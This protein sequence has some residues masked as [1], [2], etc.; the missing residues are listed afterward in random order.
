ME[1][2]G[3]FGTTGSGSDCGSELLDDVVLVV[4]CELLSTLEVLDETGGSLSVLLEETVVED[5]LYSGTGCGS[6]DGSAG[7]TSGSELLDCGTTT[8]TCGFE[9]VLDDELGEVSE[10]LLLDAEKLPACDELAVEEDSP[11]DISPIPTTVTVEC[12]AFSVQPP[13][14]HTANASDRTVM[15]LFFIILSPNI[16]YLYFCL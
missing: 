11:V 16:F 4:L 6:Y 3:G 9:E 7:S 14:M 8:L 13:S 12:S 10:K 2:T 15:N 5:E 1:P